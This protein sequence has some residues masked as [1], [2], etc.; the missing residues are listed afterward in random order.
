MIDS[1]S[2]RKDEPVIVKKPGNGRIQAGV[3]ISRGFQP[4]SR[5]FQAGGALFLQYACE[6]K[7]LGR[8]TGYANGKAKKGLRIEPAQLLPPFYDVT[9]DTDCRRRELGPGCVVSHLCQGADQGRLIPARTPAD[10]GHRCFRRPAV[11]E[12]L[13]CNIGQVTYAHDE[14]QRV[15]SCGQV[16][17]VNRRVAL[18]RILVACNDGKGRGKGP[19]RHGNAGISRCGNGG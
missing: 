2:A 16:L 6:G 19:V 8:R 1:V 10:E 15:Y 18:C 13:F 4:D 3:A 9:D 5:D 11:T 17:P 12:Q 14:D 7:G